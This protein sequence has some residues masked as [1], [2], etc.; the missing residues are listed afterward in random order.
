MDVPLLTLVIVI[1]TLA[2]VGFSLFRVFR[3][4][5]GPSFKGQPVQGTA[6]VFGVQTTGQSIQMGGHPPQYTCHIALRVTVPG[7]QPYDVTVR[8]LVGTFQMG[9]IQQGRTVAV[10][11]DSANPQNV[12]IDFNQSMQPPQ[13]GASGWPA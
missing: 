5:R 9:A 6:Q 1:P 13:A 3:T 8:Q 12:R 4:V 7:Q 10:Q 2:L 11:V